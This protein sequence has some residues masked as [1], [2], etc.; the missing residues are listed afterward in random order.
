MTIDYISFLIRTISRLYEKLNV[1]IDTIEDIPEN[2]DN[3][4]KNTELHFL[5]SFETY[6]LYYRNNREIPLLALYRLPKYVNFLSL[7]VLIEWYNEIK[8][9][10]CSTSKSKCLEKLKGIS[11][12]Y[13][14]MCK[15]FWE[16]TSAVE[17]W[18]HRESIKMSQSIT[19]E[20]LRNA[21]AK[22]IRIMKKKDIMYKLFFSYYIRFHLV[23]IFELDQ[24]V[25]QNLNILRQHMAALL[26]VEMSSKIYNDMMLDRG[27]NNF[28]QGIKLVVNRKFKDN[29]DQDLDNVWREF[30]KYNDLKNLDLENCKIKTELDEH[31]FY[32]INI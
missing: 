7:Q 5:E 8:D 25:E 2:V 27:Y 31:Y 9:L 24:R 13:F 12:K 28:L 17:K 1:K 29:L 19:E 15:D 22:D 32:P 3:L 20:G 10:N 30:S 21:Y 6:Y 14:N 4:E 11:L 23:N 26:P 18:P 16:K